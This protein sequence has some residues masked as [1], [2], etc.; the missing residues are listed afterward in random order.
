VGGVHWI[1]LAQD[2]VQYLVSMNMVINLRFLQSAAEKR[3]IK[4][5]RN[6]FKHCIKIIKI[7]S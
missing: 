7:L 2:R 1:H 5:N 4:N 6:Q 3:A